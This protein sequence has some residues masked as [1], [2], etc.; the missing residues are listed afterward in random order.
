[1]RHRS[2]STATRSF[3][4]LSVALAPAGLGLMVVATGGQAWPFALAWTGLAIV[5]GLVVVSVGSRA[6]VFPL[7]GAAMVASVLLTFEGGLFLLPAAACLLASS[8]TARG[9]RA[10]RGLP[11]SSEL[12]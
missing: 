6:V 12:S 1:M 3:R 10:T 11:E 4:A 8:L 2:S 7:A 9:A 5:I